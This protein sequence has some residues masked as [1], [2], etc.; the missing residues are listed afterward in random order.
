MMPGLH[1]DAKGDR[2]RVGSF[3]LHPDFDRSLGTAQPSV[4]A[5]RVPSGSALIP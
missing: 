1:P 2:L 4:H 3:I 5:K